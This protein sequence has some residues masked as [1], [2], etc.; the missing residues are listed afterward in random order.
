MVS[1]AGRRVLELGCGCLAAPSI[2][3]SHMGADGVTATDLLQHIVENAKSNADRHGVHVRSL[4]WADCVADSSS[5][6][7]A[8]SEKQMA[9][10]VARSQELMS[11]H[12]YDVILW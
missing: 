9:S 10:T 1:V 6:A 8:L 4:D 2:V 5:L 7:D 3:A 12:P 11:M